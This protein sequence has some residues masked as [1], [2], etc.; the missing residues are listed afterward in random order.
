MIGQVISSITAGLRFDGALNV[1]MIEFQT[2]LVPYP[3]IHYPLAI[4]SPM[5]PNEKIYHELLSVEEVTNFCFE[6]CNQMVKCDPRQGKYMA[7]CMLYRGDVSPKDINY[8]IRNIKAKKLIRFVDWCPT[9]FKIGLNYQ[10]PTAVP[11]GDLAKCERACCMLVNT[12]AIAEAWARLNVK[13]DLLYQ[14]RAFVHHFVDEG[15]EEAD[16]ADAMDNI[17]ALEADYAEVGIDTE[18]GGTYEGEEW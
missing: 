2:N 12:T 17:Q 13:F 3:R 7:C 11:G 15:M 1:D 10:P 5:L 6:P 18:E 8:A 14:K 9:G 4:Y 16:F